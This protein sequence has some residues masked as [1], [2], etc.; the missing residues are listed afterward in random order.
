VEF[1][2]HRQALQGL[3]LRSIANIYDYQSIHDHLRRVDP[4]HV[5]TTT[6]LKVNPLNSELFDL[7]L[8]GAQ[9]Y[10]VLAPSR[11]ILYEYLFA[12]WSPDCHILN[13]DFAFHYV[14]GIC[15]INF[16]DGASPICQGLVC[17]TCTGFLALQGRISNTQLSLHCGVSKREELRS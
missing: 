12:S 6:R 4:E 2:D 10:D 16:K 9:P 1:S 15:P 5:G 11:W 7:N 3:T 17:L 8:W 14:F 13:D